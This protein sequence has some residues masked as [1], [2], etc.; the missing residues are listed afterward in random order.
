MARD[1]SP[2]DHNLVCLQAECSTLAW[3]GIWVIAGRLVTTLPSLTE[4]TTAAT[5]AA[6][7][8]ICP[9]FPVLAQ[10]NNQFF[11]HLERRVNQPNK[12][13]G[14]Q[15]GFAWDPW[16][17]GKTVIRAG[18]GLFYEN[19]VFGVTLSDRP[20]RLPTGLFFRHRNRVL[21][22]PHLS[23]AAARWRF[24]YCGLLR[25]ADRCGRERYCRPREAIP[26]GCA[27]RGTAGERLLCGQYLKR[28][29][30]VRAGLP[31]PSFL[32]DERRSSAPVRARH[33]SH[34]RLCSKR[35]PALS[36]RTGYKQGRGR[37]VFE[38]RQ[39]PNCNFHHQC[40][41]GLRRK[42]LRSFH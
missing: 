28:W 41:V 17:S 30:L 9:P 39:C 33:R 1:S 3:I 18:A 14:P 13:F 38:R 23:G 11:Q 7:I 25:P 40:C 4:S 27:C 26:S 19:V 29:W 36:C 34:R 35:R 20:G 42:F 22:R 12:N 8:A 32:P 16:G 6:P 31:L 37:A 10:F 21:F 15:L 5:R 2:K 24:P